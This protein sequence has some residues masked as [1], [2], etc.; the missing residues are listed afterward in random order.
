MTCGTTWFSPFSHETLKESQ[1][2]GCNRVVL[3]H[4]N[5]ELVVI[6]VHI[7]TLKLCCDIYFFCC[8][9]VTLRHPIL[10][11]VLQLVWRTATTILSCIIISCV[12]IL[13]S[14]ATL[15]AFVAYEEKYHNHWFW[16]QLSWSV[17]V[18]A[19]CLLHLFLLRDVIAYTYCHNIVWL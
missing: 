2:F 19:R 13:S 17:V 11:F 14:M 8:N 7:A 3:W 4:P 10:G 9:K 1:S 12:V 15:L 16:L 6:C 5:T 18:I